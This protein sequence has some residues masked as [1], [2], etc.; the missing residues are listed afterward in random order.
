MTVPRTVCPGRILDRDRHYAT[1]TRWTV[2]TPVG[3]TVTLCSAA[4]ALWWLC[5]ALPA[6]LEVTS[7][8]PEGEVAA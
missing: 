8:K 6:D 2:I 7:S 3:A 5:H 4:C 1:S